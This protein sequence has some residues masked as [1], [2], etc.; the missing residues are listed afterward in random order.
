MSGSGR[1]RKRPLRSGYTTGACAAAAA[2]AASERLLGLGRKRY[3]EIPMP[4]G[5]RARFRVHRSCLRNGTA[6]VSVIKDAGDDPDVTNGAVIA[7]EVRRPAGGKGIRVKGGKGVGRVTRPGLP[8][9]PGRAAINPVPMKMIKEAVG[10]AR[11]EYGEKVPLSVTITVPHGDEI[12]GKT[13][14]ERLGIVGGISILGTTGIVSP[15]SAEA[16]KATISSAMSVARASGD[17]EV[18]LSAG[19]V[20]ERVHM[21]RYSLPETAYVMMGDH[22]EW[23]FLEAR[24]YGFRRIHLAAQWAKMLKIAMATPDTH[25][26]AGALDTERALEFLKGLGIELP[27]RGFNTAMEV[28][29]NLAEKS[30]ARRVCRKAEEYVSSVS[31][32]PAKAYLVTYEREIITADG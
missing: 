4:L 16:W 12:A 28:F 1:L 2:K 8:V 32:L 17:E 11:N 31:G 9:K 21:G 22:A 24:K 3:V 20:S 23:S 30:E 25:V 19:R 6:Y 7:A 15:L 18:V 29:L 27:D 10:E 5:G 14:N 13:L 26:R